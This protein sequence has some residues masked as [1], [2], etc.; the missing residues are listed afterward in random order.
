M[1]HRRV[2]RPQWPLLVALFLG[3][4]AITA[5]WFI[6]ANPLDS[7]P[8]KDSE[9]RY[10]EAIVGAPARVNPLFAALNDTDAALT[11]ALLADPNLPGDPAFGQLWR[12]VSCNAADEITLLCQLPQQFAPFPS[13]ATIGILP[14]HILESATGATIADSAFNQAPAGTGP[15][16]LAQLDQTKAI[17]RANPT[18]YGTKPAIDEIEVRFYPD[19]ST[20]AAALSRGDVQGLLM[21]PGVSQDD[22]DL[23]TS[24]R[25]LRAYTANRTAYTVLFLN[26]GQTPFDDK[27]LRQAVALSINVD[28]I[29][30]NLLGGRA[31]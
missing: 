31:A 19:P 1:R 21:G 7:S 26:N 8:D 5:L 17:L 29:I 18:Y 28:D 10:V 23:L 13:Y 11:Y 22:F 20:A 9:Q 24:T 25:G 4:I 14:K 27:A 16:R 6:L 30:S 15:Y 12:L 3:V 2:P